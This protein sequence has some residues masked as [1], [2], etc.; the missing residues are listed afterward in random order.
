MYKKEKISP[1]IINYCPGNCTVLYGSATNFRWNSPTL[2][3]DLYVLRMYLK[4]KQIMR[5]LA[6][7]VSW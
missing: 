7:V 1:S 3:K 4:A 5:A 6:G 2:P